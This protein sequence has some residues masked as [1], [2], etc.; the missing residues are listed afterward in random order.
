M[1]PLRRESQVFG[2]RCVTLGPS[3]GPRQVKAIEAL[4][5]RPATHKRLNAALS[6]ISYYRKFI[7]N[8]AAVA[9]P[10]HA[11]IHNPAAWKGGPA[12]T[13]EEPHQG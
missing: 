5:D 12:Y 7:R 2:T 6:L 1:H 10:L 8:F 3:T 13:T 9:K 4:E 11:K